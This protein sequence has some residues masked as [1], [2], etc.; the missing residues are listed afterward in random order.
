MQCISLLNLEDGSGLDGGEWFGL[1]ED[2]QTRLDDTTEF[3]K[4]HHA[5]E[6]A[7]ESLDKASA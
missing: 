5:A 6:K 2:V 3:S 1:T 4:V 7:L